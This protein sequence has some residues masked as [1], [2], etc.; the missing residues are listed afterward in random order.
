[1][2]RWITILGC[3]ILAITALFCTGKSFTQNRAF[4]DHGKKAI[5]QPIDGYERTTKTK[6]NLFAE[7]KT[8]SF[9]A[10]LRFTTE[11]GKTISNYKVISKG[12]IENFKRGNKMYIEY[13]P[14]TPDITRFPDEGSDTPFLLFMSIFL[15]GI[16]Y[17][18]L[19]SER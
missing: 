10:K 11:D 2:I 4:S 15:F 19:K 16:T 9:T 14:E 18:V 12:D 13:L 17:F 5:I 6:K 3:G 8:E 7:N 1:M